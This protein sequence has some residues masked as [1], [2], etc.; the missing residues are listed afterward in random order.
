MEGVVT[1]LTLGT[2]SL[3]GRAVGRNGIV[4]SEDSVS[5]VVRPL[6]SLQLVVPA[7]KVL[8]GSLVPV[9]L[10]GQDT[11]MNVYSYGSAL[12]FLNIDWT[13]TGPGYRDLESPLGGTGHL[14]GPQNSGV[15]VFR[16]GGVGKSTI[17]ATV[18]IS[19]KIDGAGQV[20]VCGS[21]F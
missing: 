11:D 21:R 9:T 18:R 13:V 1:S 10:F 12:P 2:T 4:Y 5:V 3:K 17:T 8:V 14:L 15:V 7:S 6:S 19:S 20:Q 16:G